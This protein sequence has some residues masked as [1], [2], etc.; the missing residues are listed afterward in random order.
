MSRVLNRINGQFIAR[1]GINPLMPQVLVS[2]YVMACQAVAVS[3]ASASPSLRIQATNCI[4][5]LSS[6]QHTR[7]AQVVQHGCSSRA[8]RISRIAANT[9]NML[10]ATPPSPIYALRLS[11]S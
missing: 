11:A 5:G 9:N 4:E 6:K 3:L 1:W 7:L 8:G 10:S 2:R